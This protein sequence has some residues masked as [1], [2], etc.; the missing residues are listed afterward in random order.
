MSRV[1]FTVPCGQVQ[2]FVVQFNVWGFFLRTRTKSW[3]H[4]QLR[5]GKCSVLGE[6]VLRIEV[7]RLKFLTLTACTAFPSN[8][9]PL[10][11]HW[12]E[13]LN[14]KMRDEPVTLWSPVKASCLLR[15]RWKMLKYSGSTQTLKM[16]RRAQPT[17]SLQYK[18]LTYELEGL[19]SHERL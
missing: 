2:W 19:C 7:S 6:G 8:L 16:A 1:A 15:S 10:Q 4:R 17:G 12:A 9:I 13:S 5:G 18:Q 11:K 14:L 3:L